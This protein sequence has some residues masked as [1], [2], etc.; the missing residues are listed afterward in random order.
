MIDKSKLPEG[1]FLVSELQEFPGAVMTLGGSLVVAIREGMEVDFITEAGFIYY[2]V[3][4]GES[5]EVL[6]FTTNVTCDQVEML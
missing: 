2:N 4:P 1:F 5:K 6:H 3:R